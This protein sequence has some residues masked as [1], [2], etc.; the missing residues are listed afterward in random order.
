MSKVPAIPPDLFL[1][2]HLAAHKYF[3]VCTLT[4]AAWDTLVLSPRA[5]RLLKTQ[6]WPALK[7]IFQVLRYLMPIEFLIVGALAP[8]RSTRPRLTCLVAIA[9]FDNGFTGDV[10]SIAVTLTMSA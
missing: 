8:H 2:P 7:I 10:S 5:I 3:F 6:E 9:F 4:V 1:P